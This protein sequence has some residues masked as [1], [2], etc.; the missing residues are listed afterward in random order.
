LN[1]AQ[2]LR[3]TLESILQQDYPGIECIVVDGGSTD[4]TSACLQTWPGLPKL[5]LVS[6]RDQAL[7]EAYSRALQ[8]CRGDI[9]GTIDAD[10][11]LMPDA[12]AC[13]V[14]AF[15][16]HPRCAVLY[17]AV[18]I[19]DQ[20]GRLMT[21]FRAG[22]FDLARLMRSELV[23]PFSSAFFSRS[24][25]GSALWFDDALKTCVD[26]DLWLRLGRLSVFYLPHVLGRTR[27]S[28]KSMTCR[29]STYDQFCKDKIRAVTRFLDGNYGKDITLHQAAMAGIY[30]WAAESLQEMFGPRTKIQE[31]CCRA[32]ELEPDS[33][34]LRQLKARLARDTGCRRVL[35]RTR[36]T[37]RNLRRRLL[38]GVVSEWA[39]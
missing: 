22:P 10:N 16:A 2:F 20:A 28:Q 24:R 13:V 21:T 6:H 39:A 1:R 14:E 30:L 5:T 27:L 25:C 34:R 7:G 8:R 12:L 23:P 38:A 4:G 11:Q 17:G 15:R 19:I 36:E 35:R 31:Y 3:P 29:S 26:F 9:I 32:A 33:E 37:Y 18:E